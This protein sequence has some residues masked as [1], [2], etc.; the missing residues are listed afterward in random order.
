MFSLGE[1]RLVA[2]EVVLVELV[3]GAEAAAEEAAP[4]RRVGDEADAELAQRRQDLRLDVARPQRVLGLHRGDRVD[5]VRAADRLRRGLAQPD[6]A[7][8]ALGDELGER[9]D[10]LLDRRAR[11]DAVLVVEVDVI[12]AQ[13]LQ[14]ALDR[15]PHVL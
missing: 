6:V 3:G 12:G 2:A 14:R 10:R 11:V 15:A 5:G 9:A 13:A 4:E 7:D 1:A 8:L